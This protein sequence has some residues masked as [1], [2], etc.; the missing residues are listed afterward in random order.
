[1]VG[2]EGAISEETP[3]SYPPVLTGEDTPL[4]SRAVQPKKRKAKTKARSISFPFMGLV[5]TA[6]NKRGAGLFGIA[7]NTGFAILG[8]AFGHAK[9][10]KNEQ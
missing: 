9:L 7:R 4:P 1:M 3:L 2:A 8:H 5:G 6:K 10:I